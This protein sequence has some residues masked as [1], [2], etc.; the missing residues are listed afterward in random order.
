MKYILYGL[1]IGLA[2]YAVGVSQP[3]DSSFRETL[4]ATGITIGLT[5]IILFVIGV[6]SRTLD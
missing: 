3:A 6:R 2:T 5:P 4:I 1:G